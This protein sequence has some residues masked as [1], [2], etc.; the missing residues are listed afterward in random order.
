MIFVYV[1]IR[2]L[3]SDKKNHRQRQFFKNERI[4]TSSILFDTNLKSMKVP[5][6]YCQTLIPFWR[7]NIVFSNFWKLQ[8]QS[9]NK[10]FVNIENDA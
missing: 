3:F 8:N 2:N 6:I 1:R 9:Y 4:V 5:I 7:Q 10:A